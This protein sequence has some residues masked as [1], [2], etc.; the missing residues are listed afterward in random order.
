MKKITTVL[1]AIL[2]ALTVFGQTPEKF[3]YQAVIRNS[4][5]ELVTN[6]NI[7]M[8]I[9]ILQGSVNG[10]SVYV[11]THSINTNTNGLVS[12]EIGTGNIQSGDFTNIDWAGDTFFIKTETDLTGGSDYTITGT[13]QL[14]SVPYALHAK[15]AESITGEIT[16]TDP[17][18]SDWDKTTGISITESQITDLGAYIESENDPVFT[19]SYAAEISDVDI[20]N[21]NNLSGVNTGDQDISGISINTQ[22][23]IDTASNL[24]N[25]LAE[26][27]NVLTLNNSTVFT[28]SADYQPATKKYV[29]DNSGSSPTTYNIGDTVLGGIVFWVDE[30][31]EHGLIAATS[32]YESTIKWNTGTNLYTG[33][34]NGDGLYSGEMNTALIVAVQ[35]PDNQ[36]FDFAAKVC[37]D[38][39]VTMDGIPYGDWYLPSRYELN[40][41]YLQKDIVGGFEDAYYWSSIEDYTPSAY[42]QDFSNGNQGINAKNDLNYV[43]PIRAF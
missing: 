27:N 25:D 34:K 17:V 19:N 16:E 33:T 1:L 9:S 24:R 40:L 39:S 5:N 35:M 38:Y 13:T 26:K 23:I 8:Q 11:E 28:P 22:A 37:A 29:D 10:A 42:V 4:N 30:S 14:L 20:T 32:D 12:L 3:S 41:L 21:L 2:I 7:G 15:T 18:F 6:Q 31:G 43:R 36:G